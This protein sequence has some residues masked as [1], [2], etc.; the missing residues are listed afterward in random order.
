MATFNL[1]KGGTTF[2]PGHQ[3]SPIVALEALLDFAKVNNGVG[4]VQNDVAQVINVPANTYILGVFVQATEVSANAGQVDVGDGVVAN[5]YVDNFVT[6]AL[7]DAFGTTYGTTSFFYTTADTI[8]VTQVAALTVVT[9]KLKVVA[10]AV[11]FDP[12]V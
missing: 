9:G 11:Q 3:S 2:V 8:D 4:M 5:R 12:S 10:L 1:T 7:G 6:N